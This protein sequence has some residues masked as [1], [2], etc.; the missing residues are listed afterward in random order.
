MA[1]RIASSVGVG[2]GGE[3]RLAGHQHP[4]RADPALGAAGLEERLLEDA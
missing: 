4:R 2:A 3:E 1:S